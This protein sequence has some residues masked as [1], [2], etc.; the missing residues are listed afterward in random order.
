LYDFSCGTCRLYE[1]RLSSEADFAEWLARWQGSP[2]RARTI[3]DAVLAGTTPPGAL[4]RPLAEHPQLRAPGEQHGGQLAPAAF[5]LAD[6][7][8]L[9][10]FLDEAALV[11][12]RRE[13]G[14]ERLGPILPASPGHRI[15]AELT[16]EIAAVWIDPFDPRGG[17][18]VE[19]RD[20]D[21][22]RRWARRGAVEAGVRADG[23][24]ALVAADELWIPIVE[25]R[26][27]TM[28]GRD[29]DRMVVLTAPDAE[30]PFSGLVTAGAGI[31][32]VR[33]SGAELPGRVRDAN[34]ARKLVGLLVN[35]AG[36]SGPIATTLPRG[37]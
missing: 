36:P 13:L 20:L 19:G 24:D 18:V 37:A 10:I 3:L 21:E 35:P 5:A 16:A 6:R 2:R 17:L 25:H 8:E 4:W 27:A 28:P 26:V 29:G 9:W 34:A 14:D 12:A 23:G 22:L 1:A 31:A 15:L 7:T 11:A 30:A 33:I 32:F